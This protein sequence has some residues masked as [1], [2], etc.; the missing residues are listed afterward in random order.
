MARNSGN[1][2]EIGVKTAKALSKPVLLLI[3]FCFKGKLNTEIWYEKQ[4]DTT[5]IDL[6]KTTQKAA[7]ARVKRWS[8]F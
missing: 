4:I 1:K 3:H 7:N 8:P 2:I 5:E 6:L